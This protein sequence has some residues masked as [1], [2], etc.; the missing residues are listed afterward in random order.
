MKRSPFTLI[1]IVFA[2]TGC[3]W[4]QAGYDA[5]H[6]NSNDG[7]TTITSANVGQLVDHV[8]PAPVPGTPID[9]TITVTDHLLVVS[10]QTVYAYSTKTC[11]SASG[12]PCPA[13]WQAPATAKSLASDGQRIFISNNGVDVRNLSGELLWHTAIGGTHIAISNGKVFT[14]NTRFETVTTSHTV[15]LARHDLFTFRADC[16]PGVCGSEQISGWEGPTIVTSVDL[17]QYSGIPP[18]VFDGMAHFDRIRDGILVNKRGRYD[19]RVPACQATEPTC[20][21][22][23]TYTGMADPV[24]LSPT[25]VF[26]RQFDQQF[27]T[28]A[29]G[30]VWYA[31]VTSPCPGVPAACAPQAQA[32]LT[33]YGPTSVGGNVVYAT[34]ATGIDAF[35]ENGITNCTNAT[36]RICSPLA[37]LNLGAPPTGEIQIA[38]RRV[39]VN[40]GSQIHLLSL[41]GEIS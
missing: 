34:S 13:L 36:P 40:T 8:I 14:T 18:T 31:G 37:H 10:G 28:S 24:A 11:P 33:R 20:A 30:L 2:L 7:E 39:Y 41:P 15:Y 9:A 23:A 19:L 4:L 17:T 25:H 12:S 29:K 32:A 3:G 38:N 21:P 22:N 26:D 16:D 35:A 27:P 6:S 1:V 5:G